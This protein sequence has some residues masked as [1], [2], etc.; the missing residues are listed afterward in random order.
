MG[1]LAA[2]SLMGGKH[3]T[4]GGQGGM[5]I[6][7]DEA[8]YWQAKRFADRGKPFGS[9]ATSNLFL[10]LNYRM[11]E[12]QATIGRV[13]LGRLEGVLERR[14]ALVAALGERIGDLQALRLGKVIDGATPSYWFILLRVEA[15]ALAVSKADLARALAAEGIPCDAAYDHIVAEADWDPPAGHLWRVAVPV[16][17]PAV[18][19]R[20]HLRG[21]SARC[22]PRHRPAHGVAPP[23]RLYHAG[24]GRHGRGA[25]QGRG[26]LPDGGPSA[27][28]RPHRLTSPRPVHTL[29]TVWHAS[30]CA[31]E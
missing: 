4:S 8:L 26:R 20:D 3:H 14:R 1:D 31:H 17:L 16:D 11:T 22:S 9:T 27:V 24:S 5:V 25:A 30:A 7:N 12:L 28:R 10:G 29:S 23:R 2:F 18:R 6:T 13:Q 21:D 15:E 19:P